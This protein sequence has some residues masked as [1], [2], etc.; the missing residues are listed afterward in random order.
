MHLTATEELK[1]GDLV[2]I[3]VDKKNSQQLARWSIGQEAIGV[4][5][6]QIKLGESVEYIPRQSTNDILV[7]G[8]HSPMSGQN[9]VIQASCDLKVGELVCIRQ[10]GGQSFM[11]CWGFGDEAVGIT[12]HAIKAG[13]YVNFC[14]GVST[15]DIQVKPKK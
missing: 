10:T 4:T 7:K 2:C 1:T 11:D 14:A 13:E 8:S 6:R 9:I 5:T 3:K 12:A 15:V